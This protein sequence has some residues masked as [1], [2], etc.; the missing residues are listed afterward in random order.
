MH[1]G[2]MQLVGTGQHPF[3]HRIAAGNN[4]V[5]LREIEI[6]D[7]FTLA[8]AEISAEELAQQ[9]RKTVNLLVAHGTKLPKEMFLFIKGFVYLAGAVS[10]V[11]ADV[12]L[13]AFIG[14]IAELFTRSHNEALTEAEIRIEALQDTGQIA[15]SIRRRV[16][17]EDR[18]MTVSEA[19]RT[20]GRRVGELLKV[21]KRQ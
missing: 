3:C 18:T 12:D 5:I 9:L 19:R 21:M 6:D 16:G 11:A 20:Q 14:H 1:I 2:Q 10:R 7:L 8:P 13:I 15:N 17:I 4:E